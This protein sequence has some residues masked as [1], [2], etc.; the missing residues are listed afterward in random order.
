ML[1]KIF[2]FFLLPFFFIGKYNS[3]IA[4]ELPLI[5]KFGIDQNLLS[6]INEY[7]QA[8]VNYPHPITAL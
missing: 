8:L 3:L 2:I 7:Q 5:K 6:N 4:N 1:N